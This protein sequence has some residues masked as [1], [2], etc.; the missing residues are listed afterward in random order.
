[1]EIVV[2]HLTRMSKGYCCVGGVEPKTLGQ[3]RP[4][5]RTRL[6]TDLLER[7]GGFFA[8]GNVVDLG[9]ISNVGSAPE[10]EDRLCNP[11]SVNKVQTLTEEDF[12]EILEESSETRLA[13][14]FGP[15]LKPIGYGA[16]VDNG[17][18]VAS[19]GH[20]RPAGS[21]T[22]EVDPYGKIR[23]RFS[24]GE[25]EVYPS[26]TDIRLVESDHVTAKGDRVERIDSV[27]A[28]DDVI[29]SV[30]LARAYRKPGDDRRRHFLQVNNVHIRR[31]PL[32]RHLGD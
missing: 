23:A 9:P 30:G 24:D 22:L 32:W 18:G 2:T 5:L 6:S 14:I 28:E 15:D 17:H 27:L 11:T 26:V 3:V 8:L 4:V 19:L 10:V 12:W 1:M 13:K 20:L 7:D 29:L 31:D 21:M 16:A 25:F